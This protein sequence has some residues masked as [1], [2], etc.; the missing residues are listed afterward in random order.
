MLFPAPAETHIKA[1]H[2][3]LVPRA[4]HGEIAIHIVLALD[5]LLRTLRDIRA[6]GQSHVVGKLLL[7]R[8]LGTAC[9]GVGFGRQTLR[10]NLNAADAEQFLQPIAHG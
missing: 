8:D 3:I 6:V 1:H 5:N 7:D 4:H 10:I 9:G 2:S